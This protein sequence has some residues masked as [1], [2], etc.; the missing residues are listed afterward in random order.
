[1]EFL[2]SIGTTLNT[3]T[4]YLKLVDCLTAGIE[5]FVQKMKDHGLMKEEK[6]PEE[7]E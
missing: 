2:K 5:A 1:M 7:K 4:K 3:V 6:K